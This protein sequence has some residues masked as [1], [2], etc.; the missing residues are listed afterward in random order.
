MEP[1]ATATSIFTEGI[2]ATCGAGTAGGRREHRADQWRYFM[3]VILMRKKLLAGALL[4]LGLALVPTLAAAQAVAQCS[5]GPVTAYTASTSPVPITVTGTMPATGEQITIAGVTTPAAMNGTWTV[6]NTG[7]HTGTLNGSSA[8]TGT[9][10]AG[11]STVLLYFGDG[12]TCTLANNI[13]TGTPGLSYE[14]LG[15]A[16]TATQGVIV[17]VYYCANAAGSTGCEDPGN[18]AASTAY[19][20]AT[21]YCGSGGTGVCI[22]PTVGNPCQL[23]YITTAAGTSGS[24]EPTWNTTGSC[25]SASSVTD[26]TVTWAPILQTLKSG[27]GGTGTALTCFAWSPTSPLPLQTAADGH[28]YLNWFGF[29]P[30]IPSGIS[31][32]QSV[33][34]VTDACNYL[35]VIA[36]S[37]TGLC[38]TAPCFDVDGSG[39]TANSSSTSVTGSTATT[40]Y[41]NEFVVGLAGT[42][43][44]E[45]LTPSNSGVIIDP[46]GGSLPGSNLVE[47][48]V[49]A[50]TGTQTLGATWSGGD[51]GG[52]ILGTIKTAESSGGTTCTPTMALVGVGRC[53]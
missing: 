22:Y 32:I 23:T 53:G 33:C 52:I 13:Y 40:S 25:S 43:N 45:V 29:C 3:D 24:S 48:K 10:A 19:G 1:V 47:G 15:F 2:D 21:S 36:E 14:S 20:Q 34:S 5:T 17:W 35:T 12:L 30:S 4:V 46:G 51:A 28:D 8:M 42:V 31:A 49:A 37:Y 26:G 50:T 9:L 16:P 44:D 6:T 11:S 38:A 18:W 41:T 27:T 39:N 7:T